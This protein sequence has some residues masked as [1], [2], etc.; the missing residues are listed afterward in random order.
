MIPFNLST[1]PHP[2]WRYPRAPRLCTSSRPVLSHAFIPPHPRVK[3]PLVTT[4]DA[5]G[6]VLTRRV[7]P[8]LPP[9]PPVC[10]A[11]LGTIHRN[12]RH[13]PRQG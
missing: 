2:S 12:Q 3:D 1:V 8:W 6:H 4:P 10:P 13:A 7:P 9:S 11:L 5:S